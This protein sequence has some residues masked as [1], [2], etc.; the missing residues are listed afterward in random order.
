VYGVAKNQAAVIIVGQNI[1]DSVRAGDFH[2]LTAVYNE[3]D[4]RLSKR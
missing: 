1:I 4:T 3:S 2:F